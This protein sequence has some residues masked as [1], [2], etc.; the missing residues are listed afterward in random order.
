VAERGFTLIEMMITVAIVGLLAALAIPMYNRYQAKTRQSEAKINLAHVYAS[1]KSFY[2]EYSAYIS[3]F[4]ALHFT[5]EGNKRY[6]TVGWSADMSAKVTGYGGSY[7]VPRY[8]SFNTASAF[9]CPPSEALPLLPAPV[10]A[11]AQA[12]LVGAAGEVRVGMGCDVWSIDDQKNL[13]NSRPGI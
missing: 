7:G 8:D 12:F 10:V 3:A 11:D 9:G 1:E 2:A 4:E 5:P 13:L 6:Y